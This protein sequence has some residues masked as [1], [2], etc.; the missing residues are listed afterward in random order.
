MENTNT[1]SERVDALV[2]LSDHVYEAIDQSAWGKERYRRI[3][4]MGMNVVAKTTKHKSLDVAGATYEALLLKH[5]QRGGL[6]ESAFQEWPQ[7][8]RY[9]ET[10][11][12]APLFA[13]NRLGALPNAYAAATRATHDLNENPESDARHSVHLSALAVPYALEYYPDLNPHKIAAYSLMHDV[14]EAYTGDV[15]TLGISTEALAHKHAA[16]QVALLDFTRDYEKRFPQFVRMV[17]TY[18]SLADDEAKYVKSFDK[19]DPGFTHYANKGAQ[20]MNHYGYASPEAFTADIEIGT[21]RIR[22]YGS[23]FPFVLE[24]R[25]ELT[26]RIADHTEWPATDQFAS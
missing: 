13:L 17:E 4:R 23:S 18:E 3:L 7:Y 22:S 12:K 1:S 26:K 20:L 19:L 10:L 16:E 9:V 6:D 8:A 21:D 14:V 5:M 15:P 25:D 11:P 24:D 2:R